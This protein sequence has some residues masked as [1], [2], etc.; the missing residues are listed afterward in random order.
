LVLIGNGTTLF[1]GLSEEQSA[2][3]TA[4]LLHSAFRETGLELG[5]DVFTLG[6]VNDSD[7]DA[8][9]AG[10]ELLV[11]PSRYE[12]GS[13]P[14]LDAW[15]LGTPVA[16]SAIPPFLEHLDFLGVRAATFDP[17]DE[18]SIAEAIVEMLARPDAARDMARES[19]AAIARYTWADVAKGY[20]EAFDAA[21]E[22][23]GR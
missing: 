3:P 23:G 13:G 10:A 9:I 7:A 14:A 1:K 19:K 17:E 8:L 16:M 5:K 22:R 20:R 15:A 12:A 2:D 18:G 21:V 4:V 6:Y 11:A